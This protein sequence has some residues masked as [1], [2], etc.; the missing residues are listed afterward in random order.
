MLKWPP[1]LGAV[2]LDHPVMCLIPATSY[3]NFLIY[4]IAFLHIKL[5]IGPWGNIRAKRYNATAQNLKVYMNGEDVLPV[6]SSTCH[7]KLEIGH[8][9]NKVIRL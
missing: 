1:K 7:G 9:C 8:C 5:I 6:F 2:F 4:I 3:A